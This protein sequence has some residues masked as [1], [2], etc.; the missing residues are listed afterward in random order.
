M[1]I[2]YFSSRSKLFFDDVGKDHVDFAGRTFDSSFLIYFS[3]SSGVL[4]DRLSDDIGTTSAVAHFRGGVCTV[5]L[6]LTIK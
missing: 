6:R 3:L 4:L 2:K 1:S 5:S